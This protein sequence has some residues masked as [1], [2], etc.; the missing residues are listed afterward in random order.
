MKLYHLGKV[1][2]LAGLV[3]VCFQLHLHGQG[4]SLVGCNQ[5]S[6]LAGVAKANANGGGTI[7]F[8]CQ[9]T[10]ILMSK[11]LGVLQNFVVIDGQTKN[12]T[13]QFTTNFTGC[14]PGNNGVAGAGPIAK[15]QGQ[16]NKIR[17]LT[18]RN[19]LESLQ[20]AGPNNVVENNR[21]FG[22]TCSDDAVSAIAL[23]ALN[24]MV[25]GNL[26]RNYKDKAF[27]FSYGGGR[28]EGNTFT[29][30]LAP[31]RAPYDNA[32]GGR[33]YIR[34]NV[35]NTS[36]NR[37]NCSGPFMDGRA[38]INF[39]SNRLECLRGLRVGGQTEIVVRNNYILG[40]PRAGVEIRD[41]VVAYLSG[42]VITGNGLSPGSAPAG[43]VVISGAGRA[44][45]G[46]GSMVIFGQRRVSPGNNRI[47]KNGILD[48]RNLTG[49][50]VYARNNCW[51]HA[52]AP[53][54][55]AS[56]TE[57]PIALNPVANTCPT[58]TP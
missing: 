43:G 31:F 23:S 9:N 12:I 5:T 27:Q 2:L 19:F 50:L 47:Q 20:I 49:Q 51:D 48:V 28:V 4:S 57:G 52:N 41:H 40:N 38:R 29:D 53:D 21:F 33:I 36:G 14:S 16:S 26:F 6:I 30:T 46:G 37:A 44:D 35:F 15:L 1:V 55:L 42:N 34:G 45:L 3:I 11:G 17:N 39:E 18:F 13:L 7:T 10:T 58:V 54:A 8:N 32:A 25:R 22:H 24:I 56:D